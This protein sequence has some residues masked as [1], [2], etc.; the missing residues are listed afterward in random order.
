MHMGGMDALALAV[1]GE[2]FVTASAV[3]ALRL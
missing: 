2:L 3:L 1:R